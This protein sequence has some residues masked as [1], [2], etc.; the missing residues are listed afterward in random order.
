M[1]KNTSEQLYR[2]KTFNG[3]LFS[4][5][6]QE[7]YA[8]FMK[9]ADSEFLISTSEVLNVCN[10]KDFPKDYAKK[11]KLCFFKSFKNSKAS[12]FDIPFKERSVVTIHCLTQMK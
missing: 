7:L 1:T 9:E 6:A 4:F 12:I 11:I 10:K 8:E 2:F 3:D 5:T